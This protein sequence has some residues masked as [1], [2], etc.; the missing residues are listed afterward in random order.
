MTGLSSAHVSAPRFRPLE[1][2]FAQTTRQSATKVLDSLSEGAK[3]LTDALVSKLFLRLLL[4]DE[5]RVRTLAS[6]VSR[7]FA[8]AE[9]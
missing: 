7:L 5:A 4:V 8:V 1:I 6:S 2:E 3:A 9:E